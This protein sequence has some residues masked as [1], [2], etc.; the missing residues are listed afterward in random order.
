MMDPAAVLDIQ[1]ATLAKVAW[2]ILIPVGLLLT[3]VLFKLAFLLHT[4]SDF[5]GVARYELMPLLRELQ[6]TSAHLET[7][8]AKVVASVES[9][10]KGVHAV[11]PTLSKGLGLV[12]EKLG[13]TTSLLSGGLSLVRKLFFK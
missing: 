9:V 8:S 4:V 5:V 7:L 11:K 3:V 13:E 12:C 2:V 10:E 1:L 6:Q